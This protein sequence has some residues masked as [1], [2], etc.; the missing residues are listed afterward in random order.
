MENQE[1]QFKTTLN[2]GGCI[3]KVQ[4]DLDSADGIAQW[5]VDISNQDKILTVISS[6]ISAQEV[7]DII[8]RKGFQAEPVL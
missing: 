4:P 8:K 7:V 1:L 2:C 6:G 3:S 5:N